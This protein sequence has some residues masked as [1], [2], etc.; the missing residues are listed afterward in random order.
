VSSY[1]VRD[2]NP[3]SLEDA[4][5]LAELF[6][7]FDAIWP[8]GFTNGVR[9]TAV[10][11]QERHRRMRRLAVCIAEHESGE[12]AGYCTLNSE[13]GITDRAYLPLLGASP[14]HL[15]QGVGKMLLLEMIKR[16]T[17]NGFRQVTLGTWGGNLK[18]VPLYKKTGFHWVPETNVHMRNFIPGCLTVPEGRAFFANRDWYT[19]L[20]R[21]IV[22]APD[23]VRW[24]GRIVFP[25][26]FQDGKAYLKLIFDSVSEALT[27]LETP[28]YSIACWLEAEECAVGESFPITW[29]I[30]N[31]TDKPLEVVI[32]TETDAGLDLKV[33][34][35][36][37]VAQAAT[38]TRSL[39]VLAGARPE[40][41]GED[42]PRVRSTVLVNGKPVSLE[43]GVKVVRSVDIECDGA[44]MLTGIS[45]RI[46]VKLRNR[47]DREL[48]GTL[49]LDP[50]PSLACEAL[51]Q[52]FTLPAKA[53]AQC[54]FT[55]MATA[56]GAMPSQL[57][58]A[59]GETRLARPVVF[60]ASRT[61]EV[62]AYSELEETEKAV[63][64]TPNLQVATWLRGGGC[65]L[66]YGPTAQELVIHPMAE[67]G[68]PF[69]SWRERPLF[70]DS[71]IERTEY[72]LSLIQSALPPEY[73]GL[74][75]E[76]TVSLFAEDVARIAYRVV[77]TSSLP[78]PA[79][80]R[81]TTQGRLSGA[82]VIPTLEGIVREPR[83]GVSTYPNGE[84]DA[85][86]PGVPLGEAWIACE[87]DGVVTGLLWEG[88]P[89]RDMQWTEL[90]NLNYDL[91]EIPPHS[92]RAVP[93]IYLV[94][95]KGDWKTVREWWRRLHH[96]QDLPETVKP[97]ARRVLDAAFCPTP[98]LLTGAEGQ[99]SVTLVNRRGLALNGSMTLT[100]TAFRAEPTTFALTEIDR[101]KPFAAEVRLTG[102]SEPTASTLCAEIDSGTTTQTFALPVLQL[103]SGTTLQVAHSEDG[104]F[105]ITNGLLS[106]QV[107]PHFRGAM[108]GLERN[109]VQHLLSAYPE[110][111]PFV[112][113]NPW[114]GGLSPSLGFGTEDE[115]LAKATFTGEA[116]TRTG[117]R[118]LAW[119]GVRVA[120][121]L[122]HKDWA[123]FAVETEYLTLPG[124]NVIAIVCRWTNRSSARM[125]AEPAIVAWLQPGGTRAN[126]TAHWT[127]K[128]ER[129]VQRRGGFSM[130]AN[131]E[132]WGA[133]ENPA[134]GDVLTLIT[135]IPDA[136]IHLMDM[137]DEG[138]HLYAGF[139]H[140][141]APHETKETLTWLVLTSGSTS[142]EAYAS[143]AT[144]ERLP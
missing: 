81:I 76:R 75:V 53:W 127:R 94:G 47:L 131:C 18:A 115:A 105:T 63:L 39:R 15:N 58:L 70:L 41:E 107:A 9:D 21:E 96:A 137:A 77:N 52:P 82:T 11:V 14:K 109:G 69:A 1:T 125:Q 108:T 67:L 37:T 99:A 130:Q 12:F 28:D 110:P 24:H 33:Q 98:A 36:L 121:Q 43:T 25:Y 65:G 86:P 112:W 139:N 71:R 124:S 133:V 2:F 10:S 126:T 104:L 38:L 46:R 87:G 50:H 31:R 135:A 54:E 19:C 23:D 122:T 117:E 4:A 101:E 49:S 30:L 92:D 13:A 103:G 90:L 113:W 57:R 79:V 138:A 3:E 66:F 119:Q 64:E 89:V 143:L 5:K 74:I 61:A 91:G 44:R 51:V 35:S 136:H 123:W 144:V 100:G 26:H 32:L 85:L 80:L 48:T 97:Q 29:E 93:A 132:A 134:T 84:R 6:N 142:L 59:A 102:P 68:P 60:R 140:T 56:S 17:A 62:Q 120:A 83:N 73:P 128:G 7:S 106:V 114:H 22:V 20:Q 8:G 55:L 118:G 129:M 42:S 141:F 16:V 34:E 111:R 95:G 88:R 45:Q 116:V 72:G 40:R 27:A 78:Q